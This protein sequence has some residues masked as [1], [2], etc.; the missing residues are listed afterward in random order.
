[1]YNQHAENVI[2]KKDEKKKVLFQKNVK[3][4]KTLIKHAQFMKSASNSPVISPKTLLAI[5]AMG[6]SSF[7][8][9][10]NSSAEETDKED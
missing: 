2:Q 1:M 7:A 4:V 9:L 8:K 6:N 5:K 10:T 3:R